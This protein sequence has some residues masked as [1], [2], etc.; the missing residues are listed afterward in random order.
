MC[1]PLVIESVRRELSRRG[2]IGA[3][4][5]GVAAAAAPAGAQQAP[6][7][8]PKG[9]RQV[10]DLTHTFSPSLPVYPACKTHPGPATVRDRA[11]RVCCE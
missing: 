6:V 8:M 4:A 10:I 5:A 1:A 9:F 2:F 7:R 3:I 11:R